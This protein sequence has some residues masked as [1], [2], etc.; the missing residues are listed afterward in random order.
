MINNPYLENMVMNANPV[1]L[2]IMLYDKAISSLEEAL[3]LMENPSE[4]FDL[5]ERKYKTM[6]KA[7]EIINVLDA[8]LDMEKGGEIAKNLRDIYTVLMDELTSQMFKED[9]EKLRKITN[10]LKSLREAWEEVE[11]INYGKGQKVAPGM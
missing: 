7:L 3:E 4:D 6:G 5:K 8:S 9:S 10:I 11:R 1:R 2:V